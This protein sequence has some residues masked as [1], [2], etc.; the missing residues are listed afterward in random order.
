MSKEKRHHRHSPR[1]FT[2]VPSWARFEAKQIVFPF[3]SSLSLPIDKNSFS[4]MSNASFLSREKSPLI[5]EKKKKKRK[6]N[7]NS[8]I[9]PRISRIS[10]TI[11]WSRDF[12]LS[13]LHRVIKLARAEEN[14]KEN[15][16]YPLETHFLT[17]FNDPPFRRGRVKRSHYARSWCKTGRTLWG[18][19]AGEMRVA[20]ED[21]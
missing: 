15:R 17:G 9:F 14:R 3:L 20:F 13:V 16:N 7:S 1:H 11:V 12:F 21:Y 2:L 19:G 18:E 8:Y 10:L 4:K 5:R 6:Q